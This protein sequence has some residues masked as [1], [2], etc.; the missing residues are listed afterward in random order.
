MRNLSLSLCLNENQHNSLFTVISFLDS[1]LHFFLEAQS[2]R[3]NFTQ[4]ISFA[5]FIV[6]RIRN[7][8][9]LLGCIN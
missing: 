4:P 8:E 1:T 2:A 9:L 7:F 5:L 6:F 3:G